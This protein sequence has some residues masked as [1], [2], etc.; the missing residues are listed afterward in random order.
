LYNKG[1]CDVE[2]R[3]Y[4][5]GI[6]DDLFYRLIEED[7]EFSRII[8]S[9]HVLT[10]AWWREQ[11]RKGCRAGV[12][13]TGMYALQMRNRFNWFDANRSGENIEE[14]SNRLDRIASALEKSDT[15]SK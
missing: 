13:N 3:A 15:N 4:L 14:M 8:K 7:E 10:E 2:V 6:S 5:G 12:M 9:G 1:G 11:G